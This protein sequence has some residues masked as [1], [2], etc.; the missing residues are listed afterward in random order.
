[1][2]FHGLYALW[3]LCRSHHSKR[4]DIRSFPSTRY[5]GISNREADQETLQETLATI[6]CRSVLLYSTSADNV[7]TRTKSSSP[8][9]KRKRKLNRNMSILQKPTRHSPTRSQE[10]TWQSMEI[11]MDLSRG[12]TRLLFPNGSSRERMESGYWELMGLF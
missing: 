1:M 8:I 6:V 9:T 5:L 2:G 12:K 10:R 3:Y 11:L 4:D 7:A